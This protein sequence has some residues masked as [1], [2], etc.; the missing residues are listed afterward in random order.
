M[1]LLLAK[2]A[3]KVAALIMA[4]M[5][6]VAVVACDEETPP[7]STS[8]SMSISSAPISPSQS[9]STS[10][11]SSDSSAPESS[12]S[13]TAPETSS[14][15]PADTIIVQ[16]E[17][18]TPA[19]IQQAMLV[20]MV[21]THAQNP[22]T[23][24]YLYIPGTTIDEPVVQMIDNDYYLRRDYLGNEDFYGSYF[25]DWRAQMGSRDV[26]SP[27][28]VIYGHNATPPDNPN[29]VKFAQ[30]LKYTDEDFTK[31]HQFIYF[32]TP[33]S[34]MVWQIFAV[35]YTTTD[36]QY[37]NPN[38]NPTDQLNVINRARAASQYNFGVDVTAS[39][40]I[41][42]LSTC[43]YSLDPNYP[44][45]YRYVVMAK[46]LPEGAAQTPA[47]VEVNPSIVAPENV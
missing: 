6:A 14:A 41:L 1:N 32:S 31:D 26:L 27:N 34:D 38:D 28:T 4:C 25:A 43:T 24:G 3:K 29:Q 21:E 36:F 47:T 9:T 7:D 15:P 33:E 22:D 10:Q 16:P 5:I 39:D 11:P 2:G 13:I 46:L 8:G 30:L 40:N 42:T 45:E 20:S 37:H 18:R 44:N 35:F 23:V 12:T 19:E 17:T